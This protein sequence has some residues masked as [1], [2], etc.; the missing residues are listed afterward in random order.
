MIKDGK[1]WYYIAVKNLFALLT[2][3]TSKHV[4]DF[5]CLNFFHSYSAENKLKK[6]K[7]VCGNHDYYHQ[8]MPKED[9]K[10]LE[11]NNGEKSNSPKKSSTTKIK[12]HTPSGYC[13]HNVRLMLQQINLIVMELKTAWKR[14]VRN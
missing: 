10:K 14:F 5:Y 12:K 8:E 13:L 9:N 11:F 4:G 2:G 7:N 6:H 3:I 1:K